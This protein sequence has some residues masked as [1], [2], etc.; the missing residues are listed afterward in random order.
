L[1]NAEVPLGGVG[2]EGAFIDLN[3]RVLAEDVEG[4]VGADAVD[5]DDL[6]G[7]GEGMK[8]ALDIGG[9][10]VGEDEGGNVVQLHGEFM[11][12]PLE[13]LEFRFLIEAKTLWAESLWEYQVQT[14]HHGF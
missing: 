7:P 1:V 8:S 6:V 14:P 2:I 12:F 10:V 4:G 5:D 3:V 13:T 11:A 9:F